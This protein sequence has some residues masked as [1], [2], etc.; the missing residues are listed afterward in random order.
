MD[1]SHILVAG[2]SAVTFA[3]LMWVEIRSRRK[4]AVEKSTSEVRQGADQSQSG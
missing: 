4:R 3:L 1:A 2:L